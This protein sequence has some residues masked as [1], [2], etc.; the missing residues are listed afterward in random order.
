VSV[1]TSGSKRP[2]VDNDSKIPYSRVV[3]GIS[4]S[5]RP[6]DGNDSRILTPM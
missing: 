6:P 1:D 4:C 3:V 2:L 5:K